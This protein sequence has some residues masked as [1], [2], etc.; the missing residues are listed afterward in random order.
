MD[1]QLSLYNDVLQQRNG[2]DNNK[3][4]PVTRRRVPRDLS[5]KM[6]QGQSGHEEDKTTTLEGR[7]NEL[8]IPSPHGSF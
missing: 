8:N 4:V 5:E 6:R 3:L 7:T 2:V 1:R